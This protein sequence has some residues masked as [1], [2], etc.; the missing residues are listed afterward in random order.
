MSRFT[1]EFREKF[2]DLRKRHWGKDRHKFGKCAPLCSV[3]GSEHV[4]P[5]ADRLVLSNIFGPPRG[6]SLF[7]RL[8]YRPCG[9]ACN[10]AFANM[11]VF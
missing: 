5:F 6:N 10:K 2:E 7:I 3:A 9:I 8:G 1:H 11:E 4:T